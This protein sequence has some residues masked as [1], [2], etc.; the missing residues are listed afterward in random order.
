M[1]KLESV[2]HTGITAN[3]LACDT[4]KVLRDLTDSRPGS[5]TTRRSSPSLWCCPTAPRACANP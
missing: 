2:D 4:A 1:F 3:D 5:A